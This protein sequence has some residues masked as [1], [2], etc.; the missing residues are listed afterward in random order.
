MAFLICKYL[1][2]QLDFGSEGL[3]LFG[4][5]NY[6]FVWVDIYKATC[7][8]WM[9]EGKVGEKFGEVGGKRLKLKIHY[10]RLEI[11]G[12]PIRKVTEGYFIS[13]ILLFKA[14]C[15]FPLIGRLLAPAR[16]LSSLTDK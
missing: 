8:G 16:H 2:S 1:N 4:V 11:L 3:I 7:V 12:H 9:I 5:T 6:R 14:G 13:E 15:I 10:T